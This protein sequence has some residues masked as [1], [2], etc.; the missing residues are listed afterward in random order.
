MKLIPSVLSDAA[1]FVTPTGDFS[2]ISENDTDGDGGGSC[3]SK[4]SS[5]VTFPKD[6]GLYLYFD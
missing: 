1:V 5:F 3:F 4:F 2:E 6:R